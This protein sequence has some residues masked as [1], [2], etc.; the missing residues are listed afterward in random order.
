MIVQGCEEPGQKM[1]STDNKSKE[2]P[3]LQRDGANGDNS[4]LVLQ[5]GVD[6]LRPLL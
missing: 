4:V 5:T 3:L 1:S 2:S 6:L